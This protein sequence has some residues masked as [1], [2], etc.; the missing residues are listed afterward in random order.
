MT[1]ATRPEITDAAVEAAR[2]VIQRSFE[3]E[4]WEF[5][6]PVKTVRA[7]LA[8]GRAEAV[9]AGWQTI[10]ALQRAHTERQE[11]WCPDQKPDLSF[12]GNEMAGE[13]G[14]ACNVI[15]KLERE[16]LGW[17]GSRASKDDLASELADVVHTAILC[18]I[19]AGI[20]LEPEIIAKFNATSEKNGLSTFIGSALV[21]APAAPIEPTATWKLVNEL[22]VRLKAASEYVTDA[23][24]SIEIAAAIQAANEFLDASPAAPAA[25]AEPVGWRG[26]YATA[27]AALDDLRLAVANTMGYNP[28]TWPAHRNAPL[29]IAALVALL[30][31]DAAAPPAS[32]EALR[33]ARDEYGWLIEHGT[34]PVS[35][36][37]YYAGGGHWAKEP[38]DPRRSSAW[39]SNHLH[40]IRFA[41][42]LDAERFAERA[43][44]GIPVRV[45]EHAWASAALAQSAAPVKEGE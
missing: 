43:M 20:D 23:D 30:K 13:V 42:K 14:E 28:E 19:T 15:K 39:T 40:A 33:E 27:D 4:P 18:A 16:R 6:I 11:E 8:A 17:R 10:G 36:P 3:S 5:G 1:N 29:A 21:S 12:R 41:R 37:A 25:E 9:A 32:Q 24:D 22:C 7:A 31:G 35:S 45:C 38:Y 44:A 26:P 34:S 2:A